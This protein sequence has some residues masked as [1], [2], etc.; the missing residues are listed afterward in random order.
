MRVVMFDGTRCSRRA[1]R[2][3]AAL[4]GHGAEDVQVGELHRSRLA[5]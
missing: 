4:A 5:V 3:D 1:A 2:N